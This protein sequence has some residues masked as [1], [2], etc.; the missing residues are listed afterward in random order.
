M[1]SRYVAYFPMLVCCTST[2][3][4]TIQSVLYINSRLVFHLHKLKLAK[5]TFLHAVY[6]KSNVHSRLHFKKPIIERLLHY[7]Y[8]TRTIFYFLYDKKWIG[9]SQVVFIIIS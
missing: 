4:Q 5:V 9:Y 3:Q 2:K 7:K 1:R 6:N 8:F